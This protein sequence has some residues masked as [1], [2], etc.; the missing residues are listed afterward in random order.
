MLTVC[1]DPITGAAGD[2]ILAALFELGAEPEYVS[3][4]LRT[5]GLSE[6]DLQFEQKAEQDGVV[7]GFCHVIPH[8][9]QHRRQRHEHSSDQSEPDHHHHHRRLKDILEL[10]DRGDFPERVKDRAA[11]VFRR[12]AE[13][14]GAVHGKSPQDVQFHEVGAVDSIVDI[15]GT[16]LALEQLQVDSIYVSSFKIG[17][18]TI[19]CEHG[20]M[21]V[22]AP[23]TAKL[24]EDSRVRRLNIE[25]ELTTPTGAA[26]LTTLSDGDWGD[27]SGRIVRVGTG[28]GKRYFEERPNILRAYLMEL[29]PA[30]ET[31]EVIECDL[32]DQTPEMT[33]L[34]SDHLRA[35]GAIDVVTL[36]IMMKKKRNGIRLS[37]LS[38]LHLTERLSN[39]I[40]GHSST[41]GV[42]IYSV[43]RF[44][45]PRQ[46]VTVE[47]PWGVV[48]AKKIE[49][50]TGT[51]IVPEADACAKTAENAGIP[52]RRVADW[53]RSWSED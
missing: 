2:M 35:R 50:P 12:L 51:E 18:G 44:L 45:L 14:E 6:F 26:L 43:R 48:Q 23:A 20:T 33:A 53:A 47:T 1:F 39:Q 52:V 30:P 3:E 24:L 49:R 10:I 42:R 19:E 40:L 46:S 11:A 17:C 37:V 5:M 38:P 32:D 9:D 13:A 16:C 4:K 22:P 21:P 28:H 36:P 25:S 29:P 15:V 27:L 8:P 7:Y 34:L 31:V 41:I